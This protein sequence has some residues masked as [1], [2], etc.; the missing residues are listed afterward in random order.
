MRKKHDNLN[1]FLKHLEKR[2]D[3]YILTKTKLTEI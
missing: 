2:Y 3:T 1:R